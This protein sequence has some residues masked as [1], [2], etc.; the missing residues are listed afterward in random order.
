MDQFVAQN[1][2]AKYLGGVHG[3]N[4]ALALRAVLA[5]AIP[6]TVGLGAVDSL[7]AGT[8]IVTTDYPNH[9]PE[10]DYLV[11]GTTAVVTPNGE[12]S[13]ADGLVAFLADRLGQQEMSRRCEIEA[14]NYTLDQT[15]SGFLAGARSALGSH[16]P[17]L[18]VPE[19]GR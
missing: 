8:P 18:N 11:D 2:W 7:V 6:G 14:Q 10:F 9:A 5:M 19:P 4:K 13:Y 17:R 15:V 3:R 16:R 12:H 1:S